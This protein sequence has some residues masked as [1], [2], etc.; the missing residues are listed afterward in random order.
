MSLTSLRLTFLI[1]I[2][3]F[4]PFILAYGQEKAVSR[5]G[6]LN[7]K[8][9]ETDNKHKL[10]FRGKQILEFEGESLELKEALKGN[11]RDF[12]IIVENSG[13]VA[14]PSQ[15]VIVE[16]NKAGVVKTS[17]EFGCLPPEKTKLVNDKVVVEINPYYAH[18]ELI[19]KKELRRAERAIEV[20]TWDQGQLSQK[21]VPR[22]RRSK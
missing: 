9:D 5:F 19:S 21:T 22:V 1:A 16:L 2:S 4:I 3:L 12:V 8:T 17:E 18:P 13:G 11:N 15:V 14:C 6:K 10:F 20:Y 7:I